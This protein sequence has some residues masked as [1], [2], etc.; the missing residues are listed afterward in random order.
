MDIVQE[1]KN[2]LEKRKKWK[3]QN[4]NSNSYF[5]STDS[6]LGY[7]NKL[8]SEKEGWAL[9]SNVILVDPKEVYS[10]A[11]DC[12]NEFD[13]LPSDTKMAIIVANGAT[14]LGKEAHQNIFILDVSKKHLIRCEPMG[15]IDE[16]E[17]L[18][19]MDKFSRILGKLNKYLIRYAYHYDINDLPGCRVTSLMLALMY[20]NN[21]SFSLLNKIDN[22]GEITLK[23]SDILISRNY[24]YREKRKRRNAYI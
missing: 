4:I 5:A 12:T 13:L 9:M 24:T 21:I 2:L 23:I 7:L 1:L 8:C 15:Y 6:V 17:D 19:H 10:R 3:F 14:S 22:Y 16:D 11:E 20:L 18:Y